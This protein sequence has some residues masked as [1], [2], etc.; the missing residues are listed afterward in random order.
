MKIYKVGDKDKALC[1][2]CKSLVDTT[3]QIRDLPIRGSE[4]KVKGALAIVCDRCDTVCGFPHQSLARVQET[5]KR[6]QERESIDSRVPVQVEDIFNVVCDKLS[7]TVDFK[8]TLI[9]YYAKKMANAAIPAGEISELLKDDVVAG[10]G[11]Y[12]V[13]VKGR[14]IK[15]DFK[16]IE[17]SAHLRSDADVVKAIAVRA[18]HDVL[19]GLNQKT[20][21]EL[22]VI[23]AAS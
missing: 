2:E 4:N 12:R 19:D 8:G 3:Y 6:E 7:A 18:K 10:K 13:S 11:T 5:V 17:K 21:D 15:T 20:L 1:E 14:S 23:A 22:K 16:A 9:R